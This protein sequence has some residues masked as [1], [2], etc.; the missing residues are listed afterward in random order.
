MAAVVGLDVDAVMALC[1]QVAGDDVLAPANLNGGGQVVV[2]GHA[3]AVGRL[4]EVLGQ[5]RARGQLLAVSAP[6]HCPLMAPAA[7]GLA[8]HLAAV[9]FATPAVPV[10]TSVDARPVASAGEIADLL[11]RQVT[12]PVRWEDTVRA[13]LATEPTVALEVGP[14]RVLSG[15]LRRIAPDLPAVTAGDVEGIAAAREALA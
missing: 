2:A 10:F 14:G 13:M 9:R 8:R 5:H 15:L 1:R 11:V 12:A 4:L 6:F 3:R 7:A